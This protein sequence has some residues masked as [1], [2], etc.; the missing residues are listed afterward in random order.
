M[1]HF[2]P[3][4]LFSL[5]GIISSWHALQVFMAILPLQLQ[6]FLPAA[7]LLIDGTKFQS[8]IDLGYLK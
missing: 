7:F 2:R 6:A 3:F 8:M 4:F 1:P 5:L